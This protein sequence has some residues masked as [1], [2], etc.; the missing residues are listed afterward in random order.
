MS[1]VEELRTCAQAFRDAAELEGAVYGEGTDDQIEMEAHAAVLDKAADTIATLEA[2]RDALKARN[3]TLE[4]EASQN[5]T[6]LE[7]AETEIPLLEAR[8]EGVEPVAKRQWSD[9]LAGETIAEQ[10]K[11]L[12]AQSE[13]IRALRAATPPASIAG[14]LMKALKDVVPLIITEKTSS[15]LDVVATALADAKAAGVKEE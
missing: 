2:E 11:L 6:H 14:R 15:A 4:R 10:V 5:E 12:D 13:T 3:E 9:K 8:V 1:D 7:V